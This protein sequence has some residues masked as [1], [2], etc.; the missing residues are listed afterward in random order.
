MEDEENVRACEGLFLVNGR[1]IGRRALLDVLKGMVEVAMV[2]VKS[3]F[4]RAWV[5]G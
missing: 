3:S 1:G 5:L 4:D 2:A